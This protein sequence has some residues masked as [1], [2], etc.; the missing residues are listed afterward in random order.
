MN[1]KLTDTLIV[2]AIAGV[3]AVGVSY[4]GMGEPMGSIPFFGSRINAGVGIFSAVAGSSLIAESAKNYVLPYIPNNSDYAD[5]EA[6]LV[7]PVLNGLACYGL[8]KVAA[9]SPIDNYFQV[10]PSFMR[11]FALG[12]GSEI[13]SKYAYDNL[14]KQYI[15][16]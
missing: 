10:E 16:Q 4:F 13:F 2:P 1:G 6:G 5:L 3:T 8:F 9:L 15:P 14:I 11:A 12:A 7:S